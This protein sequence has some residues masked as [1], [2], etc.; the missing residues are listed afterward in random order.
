[1]AFSIWQATYRSGLATGTFQI[2]TRNL[3][4]RTLKDQTN[5]LEQSISLVV[6]ASRT[7][8]STFGLP[9]VRHVPAGRRQGS[10][11]RGLCSDANSS[12]LLPALCRDWR[13]TTPLASP[14][15]FARPSQAVACHLPWALAKTNPPLQTAAPQRR[16]PSTP[17]NKQAIDEQGHAPVPR[18]VALLPRKWNQ[19]S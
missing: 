15:R 18:S 1:M 3:Q 2:T 4:Q 9:C 14:S 16:L 8:R 6:A 19:A 13:A 17:V 12:R 10:G 7:R 11:V 5:H